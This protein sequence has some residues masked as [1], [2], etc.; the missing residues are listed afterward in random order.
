[1]TVV[2]PANRLNRF[3]TERKFATILL[4]EDR[5]NKKINK[6]LRSIVW[7][8]SNNSYAD[9]DKRFLLAALL[10]D[11]ATVLL[12]WLLA[13]SEKA[14][15]KRECP[16]LRIWQL[17]AIFF[18]GERHA[19]PDS[20]AVRVLVGSIEQGSIE[21]RFRYHAECVIV[22]QVN[23]LNRKKKKFLLP[24]FRNKLKKKLY[25]PALSTYCTAN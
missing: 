3:F 1:M 8:Y 15:K 13:I 14:R 6:K 16:S 2:S 4:S 20:T 19:L 18:G 11:C 24:Y 12:F 17:C 22:G 21:V 23:N 9:M 7:C 10:H 25:L 5:K